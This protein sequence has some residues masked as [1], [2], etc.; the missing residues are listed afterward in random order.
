M[1]DKDKLQIGDKIY[2]RGLRLEGIFDETCAAL[3]VINSDT[4]S[5]FIQFG[6]DPDPKEVSVQMCEEKE[7]K[8]PELC[9]MCFKELSDEEFNICTLCARKIQ[10]KLGGQHAK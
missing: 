10:A 1:I 3:E 9:Q 2:H 5:I 8:L 4:T 6:S 7:F